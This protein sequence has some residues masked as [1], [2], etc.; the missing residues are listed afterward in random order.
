MT[1]G[2]SVPD[3]KLIQQ[4][5]CEFSDKQG[6]TTGAYTLDDARSFCWADVKHFPIVF[7]IN[8]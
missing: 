5:D 7:N 1:V 8:V 3:T 2:C 4:E 6:D